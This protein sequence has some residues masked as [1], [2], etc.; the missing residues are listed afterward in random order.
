MENDR[1][2]NQNLYN[3]LLRRKRDILCDICSTELLGD[4]L[5]SDEQDLDDD[6]KI[7]LLCRLFDFVERHYRREG[8]KIIIKRNLRLRKNELCKSKMP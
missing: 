6:D 7:E 1:K 2:V 5:E 4:I 3:D 8:R